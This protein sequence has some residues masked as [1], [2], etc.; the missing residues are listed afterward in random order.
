M[1]TPLAWPLMPIEYLV[2]SVEVLMWLDVSSVMHPQTFVLMLVKACGRRQCI[3]PRTRF[4]ESLRIFCCFLSLVYA[5]PGKTATPA[6]HKC[7]IVFIVA[8]VLIA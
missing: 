5:F 8:I 7:L 4:Q 6:S 2:A 1:F 3:A